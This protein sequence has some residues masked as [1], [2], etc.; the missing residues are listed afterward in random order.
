MPAD[1]FRGT[2]T[3]A[4]AVAMIGF[5]LCG[6]YGLIGGLSAVGT[7][8]EGAALAPLMIGCGVIGIAIAALIGWAGSR[9]SGT[10]ER[11]QDA[12]DQ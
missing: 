7:S 9:P 6:A 12:A 1:L 5:G 3:L 2:L 11:E 4:L 10:A 8:T